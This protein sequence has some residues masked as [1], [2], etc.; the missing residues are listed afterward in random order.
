MNFRNL[1]VYI[2]FHAL[3]VIKKT[4][5]FIIKTAKTENIIFSN[6]SLFIYLFFC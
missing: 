3:E 5:L 4:I 6:P 2:K 1:I